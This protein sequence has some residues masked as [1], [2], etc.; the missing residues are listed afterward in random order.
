MRKRKT[1]FCRC[2]ADRGFFER[3][4]M[5]STELLSP[6]KYY[7]SRLKKQFAEKNSEYFDDL[8]KRSGIDVAENR[9]TVKKYKNAAITEEK[10]LKKLS[11]A[12]GLK[13]FLIVLAVILFIVTAISVFLIVGETENIAA[14][15]VVAIVSF[16][17]AV[18]SLVTA[19]ARMPK[20]IKLRQKEYD[21]CK[22]EAEKLKKLA[23]SQMAP[24]NALFDWNMFADIMNASVPVIKMDKYFD[25]EKY[26]YLHNKYGFSDD[27]GDNASTQYVLSGSIV[28]NPFLIKRDRV[29][30]MEP[31][32]YFGSIVISWV[33]HHTDSKGNSYTVTR[34]Q[35]LT[36][37]VT[38]PAPVYKNRT[39]LAYG[40]D[41]APSLKFTRKPSNANELNEKQIERTVKK[42]E[43]KLAKLTTEALEDDD[44]STN[45]TAMSNSEFDVL[46]GALDRNNEV[47]YRLLF[48]PLAQINELDL[49]KNKEPFGDDFTFVK[50]ECMNY[51][52][53]GHS[54]AQDISASPYIYMS[55][56]YDESKR[57]FDEYNNGLFTSVYFDL[58]PLI[59]IPLYQQQK[60]AE[61]IYGKQFFRNYTNF[62]AEVI[63]NAINKKYLTPPRAS[64]EVIIKAEFAE[65]NGKSDKVTLNAKSFRGEPRV[66]VVPRFGGDGRWHSVPVPWTEYIPVSMFK[67][68]EMRS[69]PVTRTEFENASSSGDFNAFLKQRAAK[70]SVA[71]QRGLMA[72]LLSGAYTVLDDEKLETFF[73]DGNNASSVGK[74]K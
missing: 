11:S 35:T 2:S 1:A 65:K 60:P 5:D 48:T 50:D 9:R 36:A 23:Y 52:F 46:F 3:K 15:I 10:A 71:M 12:K 13:T 70:G 6:Y 49:I 59:S 30:T 40:N 14:A 66:E 29:C 41:A 43:K 32:Q 62:E 73:A 54:A 69:C 67:V 42:G 19:L 4:I 61:Y 8:V 58:A 39:S 72:M 7:N 44:D 27:I 37:S 22:R 28:G 57:I 74:K 25:V 20:I 34:T 18:F 51:I 68:M 53:S 26:A 55:Y 17:G 38:K 45:F 31:K 64:T 16:I 21:K 47:E 24:L 56:D 33:E 63:A